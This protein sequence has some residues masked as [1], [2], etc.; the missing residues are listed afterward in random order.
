[1]ILILRDFTPKYQVQM[2]TNIF[3]YKINRVFS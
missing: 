1:M 2:K 3:Y